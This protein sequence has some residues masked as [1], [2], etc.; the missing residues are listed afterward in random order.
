MRSGDIKNRLFNN[1]SHLNLMDSLFRYAPKNPSSLRR[2]ESA[3][4]I[5]YGCQSEVL[6]NLITLSWVIP[7]YFIRP[8]FAENVRPRPFF[9]VPFVRIYSLL[10]NSRQG[11]KCGDLVNWDRNFECRL[12]KTYL[13]YKED[14]KDLSGFLP[15]AIIKRHWAN[16]MTNYFL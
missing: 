3:F 7:L 8:L 11:P 5:Q 6:I 2:W 12:C 15:C 14:I 9:N 10:D 4:R 16:S 13:I 1:E